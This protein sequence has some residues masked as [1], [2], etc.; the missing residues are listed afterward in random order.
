LDVGVVLAEPRGGK[1]GTGALAVHPDRAADP[2]GPIIFA[3]CTQ[4]QLERSGLL[5]REN[6]ID[7]VDRSGRHTRRRELGRE[8]FP[9]PAPERRA[10][11]F[12][13]PCA[14]PSRPSLHSRSW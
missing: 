4:H 9:S 12:V 1:R 6:V 8:P 3:S 11:Q 10:R 5:R 2:D 14:H 13:V 7:T